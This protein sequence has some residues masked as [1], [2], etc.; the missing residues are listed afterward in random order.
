MSEPWLSTS[1]MKTRMKVPHRT[2]DAAGEG[3][4]EMNYMSWPGT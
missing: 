4:T 1:P 2:G 3:I